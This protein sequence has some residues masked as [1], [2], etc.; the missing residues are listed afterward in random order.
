MQL[1]Y[2]ERRN[3]KR[4]VGGELLGRGV[5]VWQKRLDLEA[6]AGPL[7]QPVTEPINLI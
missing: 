6:I 2:Q 1:S 7:E 5:A 3:N 4:S